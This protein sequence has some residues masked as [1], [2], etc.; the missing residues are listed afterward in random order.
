M[1]FRNAAQRQLDEM[2]IELEEDRRL[3]SGILST[4]QSGERSEIE[5]LLA[6]TREGAG[7]EMVRHY[8]AW[9]ESGPRRERLIEEEP[10]EVPGVQIGNVAMGEGVASRGRRMSLSNVLISVAEGDPG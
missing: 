3:L 6:M 7:R 8:I 10:G 2:R 1:T 4:L 5:G 9:L